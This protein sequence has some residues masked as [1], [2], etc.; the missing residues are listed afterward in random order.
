MAAERTVVK[1]LPAICEF[2]RY[3]LLGRIAVGGMAEIFLARQ[4]EEVEGAGHRYVVI[5]RV[6]NKV[7]E[8]PRFVDMFF[9]EAR[10]MMRLNHPGICHIYEFGEEEG[11]YFLA[12]EWI[13]GVPLGKLIRYARKRGGIP[14]PIAV[15][16]IAQVAEALHHAHRAKDDDGEVMGIVHRDVSPQNIMIAYDGAVKLIDFGIAKTNIQHTKT[17]I[18]QVKG[19][20]AYMAPEQC[21]GEDI[22]ARTD[23]FALAI[24]LYEALTGRALYHRKTEYE[25]MRAV[26]EKPVPSIRKYL[27]EHEDL[28]KVTRK[29]LAKK[30]DNRYQT[31]G[32][33]QV[34]LYRWLGQ[35]G[36]V[37]A[38]DAIV[39]LLEDVFEEEI[40]KGPNVDSKPF[41]ESFKSSVTG[42]I[43]FAQTPPSDTEL[44]NAVVYKKKRSPF[45]ILAAAAALLL[46]LGVGAMWMWGGDNEVAP[47][48]Q[49]AGAP[50][51]AGEAGEVS[52]NAAAINAPTIEGVPEV[53]QNDPE[54]GD[55]S[56]AADAPG[57]VRFG[58]TPEG[59]TVFLDSVR[60]G[61][62][63]LSIPHIAP[64]E[65]LV[66]LRM[67]HFRTHRRTITIEAG[68][69]LEVAQE[70]TARR[71]VANGTRGM[72]SM[73]GAADRVTMEASASGRLSIN[74]RPWSK[75]YVGRRL[76]GTT[77][78]GRASVPA[79]TVR[80]RLVDR[81]GTEHRRSAMVSENADERLFFDLR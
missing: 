73:M 16:I 24:C 27:P 54:S 46:C 33:L 11:S 41:G 40:R 25:T 62:T 69:V 28:D 31:A 10:L 53:F 42:K 79:G 9:D 5:K 56:A 39:E 35:N 18:G 65:H 36:H 4:R 15:K 81:D 14:V 68:G 30:P 32:E 80:L 19:K 78:I 43:E 12:M 74:T 38:A 13:D 7:A 29:A 70:M 55:D 1:N 61:R 45:P 8:D 47:P 64:G 76:L 21:K 49:V 22:D 67:D 26:V 6:T 77:P 75:V 17:Q 57:A 59:A 51:E 23:V 34:A 52:D 48:E 71:R 60:V 44:A 20:F 3:A 50:A 72:S 66:E 63:P 2:G 37:I 58:S